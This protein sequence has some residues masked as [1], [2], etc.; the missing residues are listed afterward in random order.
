MLAV[1]KKA[2][3]K[4]NVLALLLCALAIATAIYL[5]GCTSSTSDQIQ[6]EES[7]VFDEQPWDI[8][9]ELANVYDIDDT[10]T[11][12]FIDTVYNATTSGI[13]MYKVP[14]HLTLRAIDERD[15]YYIT[16]S[17]VVVFE[18]S[19]IVRNALE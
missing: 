14:I 6:T 19:T 13:M 15:T 4:H 5:I 9:F 10:H 8:E 16:K 7:I 11:Y 2:N 12:F 1:S 3:R 18:G 17:C